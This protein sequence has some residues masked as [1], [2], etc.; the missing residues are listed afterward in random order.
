MWY[1]YY[2]FHLEIRSYGSYGRKTFPEVKLMRNI[3]LFIMAN[4]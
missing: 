1:L 3:Y 4:K 2:V